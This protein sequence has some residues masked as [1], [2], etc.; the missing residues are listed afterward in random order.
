MRDHIHA[1]GADI[2][3]QHKHR[4]EEKMLM[5]VAVKHKPVMQVLQ[6]CSLLVPFESRLTLADTSLPFRVRVRD[7][8]RVRSR[9]EAN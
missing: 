1:Y 9:T 8:D 5:S 7:R 2:T 3:V 4:L 6:S